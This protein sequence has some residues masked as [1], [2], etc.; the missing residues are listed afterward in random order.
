[1][2]ALLE[3]VLMPATA[4]NGHPQLVNNSLAIK[5]LSTARPQPAAVVHC[6]GA[7]DP[8]GL[9]GRNSTH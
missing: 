7:V 4:A 9:R 3:P 1:M 8:A 5:A 6:G 2:A